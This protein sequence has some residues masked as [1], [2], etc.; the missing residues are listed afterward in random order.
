MHI[1]PEGEIG[2]GWD[3]GKAWANLQKH[4]VDLADATTAL[5]DARAITVRDDVSA[6]GEQ[7]L[8]TLGKDSLRRVL[9][10]AYTWRESEIRLVSA[11]R[12]TKRERLQYEERQR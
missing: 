3:A 6:V 4:G 1:L 5:E 12:A 11:R 10:V 9:V 8:V 7:R 2:F